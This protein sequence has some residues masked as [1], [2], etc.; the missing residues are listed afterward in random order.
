M[1]FIELTDM[2]GNSFMIDPKTITEIH[3]V[4]NGLACVYSYNQL[5]GIETQTPYDE[6]KA[7]LGV[8]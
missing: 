1:M 5:D 4:A 3:E 7:K 6:I 2:D 8:E